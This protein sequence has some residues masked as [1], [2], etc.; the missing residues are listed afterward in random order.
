MMSSDNKSRILHEGERYVQ[1]GKITQA[2]HEYEKIVKDDPED[3]LTLNIIGDLHLREGK[4]SEAN[5]LFSQVAESYAR[6]NFLLKAIAVYKKILNTDAQNLQINSSVAALYMRQGMNV[7]ARNQYILLADLCAQQGKPREA[8]EAYEKVAEIDPAN[9]PVQLKLAESYL[10]Q[11]SKG[12]AYESLAQAARAQMKSGDMPAA[13]TS[14]RRALALNLASS[15][16]L[17]GF[18]ESA[19]QAGDLKAALDQVKESI[20]SATRDPAL[21]EVLG[22]AYQAAGDLDR[23]ERYFRMLFNADDSRFA[24]FFSLSTAFL[25]SGNPDQALACLEPVIPV[26]ISRRATDSLADAYHRIL[27]ANT[28]HLPTLHKLS[29]IFFAANDDRRYISVLEKIADYHT[30][31]G[32]PS[33]ALE[34]LGK[35]LQAAPDN[36][37]YLT[38]HR[39]VFEQAFPGTPYRLPRTLQESNRTSARSL[40]NAAAQAVIE[41]AG[42]AGSDSTIVEIDLLL[43]YGM[44]EKALE[45]L[46]GLEMRRPKDRDVRSRLASLFRE[47]GES[48]LAAEQYIL[49]SALKR[50]A[51]EEEAAK[52]LLGEATDL[53]PDLA[54]SRLDVVAFAREHGMDLE[55]EPANPPGGASSTPFEVDL[56]GDLSEIF[57]KDAQ[58]LPEAQ[59][60]IPDAEA[61]TA[62]DEYAQDIPQPSGPESIEEQLQEVDFYIRLGFHDEARAKLGE[63]TAICPDH[64]DLPARCSQL[65]IELAATHEPAVSAASAPA[66]QEAASAF[67]EPEPVP[68]NVPWSDHGDAA[69][70]SNATHLTEDQ[71][72]EAAGSSLHTVP[73]ADAACGD[74]AGQTAQEVKQET[75]VFAAPEPARATHAWGG[76]DADAPSNSMFVDIIE[77]VNSLTN[78]EIT[79]ED[80]E[81]HF[82]LGIAFRE[83]GLTED[84]IKEFQ[85][86]I[87]ALDPQESPREFIQCCGML[88]TCFL[89]RDMPRSAIRWCRTGLNIKEISSH[90]TMALRYDMAIANT[91]AGDVDQALESLGTIF[92]LDP[93]YRDVAQ[94]IDTLKSGL[95]RHAL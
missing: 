72:L 35:I 39:K 90:E 92:G 24:C 27:D 80:F 78:L 36:E 28:E 49:L 4:V 34:P 60:S 26:V 76:M 47:S 44:K 12:K 65:G 51:G 13:M 59:E 87:K 11:D 55:I 37:I 6:N 61:E 81:T 32:N 91:A 5:R 71:N 17:K 73:R 70:F 25:E 3:I 64:P 41:S 94:R 48:R 9:S 66:S 1:Q 29:E 89:E 85:I 67:L 7:D 62:V 38:K 23:A 84:G 83:M 69:A 43:N 68:L 93:S 10:A 40:N 19:L 52:K 79:R 74:P 46:R 15:D 21:L 30:S 50:E 14:F 20:D 16:A 18:L 58:G 57:F 42:D 53:A 82:N 63:I 77:E 45:L 54:N 56:S 88:S 95:D 8:L 31:S 75:A 86:A 22:C 2:I 33:E